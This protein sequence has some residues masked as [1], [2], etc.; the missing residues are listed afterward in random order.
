M[1]DGIVIRRR[2]ARTRHRRIRLDSTFGSLA[3]AAAAAGSARSAPQLTMREPAGL[4]D[5]L[6]TGGITTAVHLG[7]LAILAYIAWQNAAIIKEI[8]PVRIIKDELIEA[9]GTNTPKA[10]APRSISAAD[11]AAAQPI[12]V[13]R[14]NLAAQALT[15]AQLEALR[16]PAELQRQQV[17]SQRTEAQRSLEATRVSPIDMSQLEAARLDPSQLTAPKVDLSGP[18]RIVDPNAKAISA[19]QAFRGFSQVGKVDYQGS[20]AA[21]S[22][23]ATTTAVGPRVSTRVG[24]GYATGARPATGDGGTPANAVPCQRS[25]YVGRYTNEI[26][27]RVE[28][29]WVVPAGTGAGEQVVLEFNLD[30]SG[31]A[32]DIEWIDASNTA[33]GRSA[34]EA[35]RQASPFPPMD[36]NVRCMSELRWKSTFAVPAL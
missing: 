23:A 1:S 18:R 9:P 3:V 13:S 31:A 22:A 19:P 28:R 2:R 14:A 33:L 27:Q 4:R 6:I 25:A 21:P 12:A 35:L 8:I 17:E 7:L 32:T 11:M 36:E 15:A 29:L 26:G 5:S 20:T 34:V 24:G 16:A 30:R 10:L